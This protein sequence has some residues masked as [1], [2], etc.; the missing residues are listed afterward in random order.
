MQERL[1]FPTLT[2]VFR[3]GTGLVQVFTLMTCGSSAKI[4]MVDE[5]TPQH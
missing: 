5:I 2:G 4:Q 3:D 1:A